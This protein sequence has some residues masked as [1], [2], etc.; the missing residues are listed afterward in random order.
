MSSTASSIKEVIFLQYLEK[1]LLK[2]KMINK[3]G[4]FYEI[5]FD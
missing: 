4:M 3:Q 5:D 2:D 1:I